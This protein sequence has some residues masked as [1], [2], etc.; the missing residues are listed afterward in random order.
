MLAGH[1]H[2]LAIKAKWLR[3]RAEEARRAKA[4]EFMLELFAEELPRTAEE[5]EPGSTAAAE[6]GK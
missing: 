5:T 2:P 1:L 6:D 3:Q 4:R